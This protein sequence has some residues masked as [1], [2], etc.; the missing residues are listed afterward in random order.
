METD[1]EIMTLK[2][3][4]RNIKIITDKQKNLRPKQKQKQ[5]K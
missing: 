4:E 5:K 3:E 2:K 1:R